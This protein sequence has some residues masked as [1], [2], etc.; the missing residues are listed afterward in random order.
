M[1]DPATQHNKTQ[2]Q[3][4][5]NWKKELNLVNLR[6]LSNSD[7]SVRQSLGSGSM[8]KLTAE[9]A[10]PTELYRGLKPWERALARAA[11]VSM[12]MDKAVVTGRAALR[13]WE[14]DGWGVEKTVDVKLLG[15]GRGPSRRQWPHGVSYISGYLPEDSFLVYEGMRVAKISR[16]AIDVARRDGLTQGV[17]AMDSARRKWPGLTTEILLKELELAGRIGNRAIAAKAIEL[18][19]A[20]SGSVLETRA[21]LI[22]LDADIPEIESIEYQVAIPFGADP[23]SYYVVDMQVNGWLVLEVDGATKYRG[24]Y[25]VSPEDAIRQER[26]R[27]KYLQNR[28]LSVI[29]V[30]EEHLRPEADGSYPL[31]GLVAR[32]LRTLRRP[33]V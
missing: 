1:S 13:M 30:L 15:D 8:T 19:R 32:S 31:V 25:G 2:T 11:A 12:T 6:S 29:R 24:T 20:D 21:R 3:S 10:I 7:T 5:K 18:S 16:A 22:I 17:V 28:G 33:A 27:E 23:L 4:M 14:I 26:A 9:V